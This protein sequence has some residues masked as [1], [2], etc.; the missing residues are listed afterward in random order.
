MQI[1]D[2]DRSRSLALTAIAHAMNHAMFN[3]ITPLTLTL[4]AYFHFR[5][6]SSIALGITMYLACYG[7]FQVPLGFISDRMP[8]KT[9][10]AFGMMLNG[11]AIAMVAIFPTYEMFLTGL[12]LAGVGAAAYHPVGAAYL[13][14]LYSEAKGRALGIAGIGAT[15]GLVFGPLIGAFLCAR[16][17]WRVTFLIFAAV[18]VFLGVA[19]YATAVEP[20]RAG[21]DKEQ[22]KSGWG[23]G[24]VLFLAICATIFTFREFC[25]W[26]CYYIIPMFAQKIHS[27][28][29]KEAA[30]VGGL[31]SFGGFFAQPLGG[32]LSDRFGRRWLMIVLLFFIVVFTLLIPVVSAKMLFPVVFM[33]SIAYTATVPI[34]DALIADRTPSHI[35]GSVFGIFMAAGIGISASSPWTLGR[36]LDIYNSNFKGFQVG[37]G[38]LALSVTISMICMILFRNAEP[39]R[40]KSKST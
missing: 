25:G 13:S 20:P 1:T 4:A 7:F 17:E 9:L 23:G 40:R 18:S 26:G 39:N 31:Q 15:V 32:W 6:A 38:V 8:R 28:P 19:Y 11:A 3:M 37:F 14:D 2:R 30:F 24:I 16:F 12:A 29:L 36:I 22:R 34:I 5:D 10:L 21:V 33:Y 35:R 27:F